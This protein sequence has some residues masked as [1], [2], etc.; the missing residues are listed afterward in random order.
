MTKSSKRNSSIELL[1]IIAMIII[2]FFHFH[3]RNFGMYVFGNERINEEGLLLHS[4]L[5]H[6]GGLGVP[7]F[8]FISGYYGMKFKKDRLL[9]INITMY[10]ICYIINNRHLCF[11]RK[12]NINTAIFL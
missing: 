4:I 1:R 2:V 8:M 5:H 6:L 9:D 3:A 11:Y 7:C 10:W 12:N